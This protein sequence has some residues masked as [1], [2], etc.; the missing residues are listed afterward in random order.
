MT[1]K[2]TRKKRNEEEMVVV[3]SPIAKTRYNHLNTPDEYEG[4]KTFKCEQILTEEEL[5]HDGFRE[6]IEAVIEAAYQQALEETKSAKKRKEIE[7]VFPWTE[8]E[9]DEG[10]ETGDWLVRYK[11]NPHTQ[12][13]KKGKRRYPIVDAEGNPTDTLV[14]GG[15]VIRVKAYVK[16]YWMKSTNKVGATL[17]IQGIQI[18]EL[19]GGNDGDYGDAGFGKVEGGFTDSGG[20]SRDDGDDF[21]GDDDD[22][23]NDDF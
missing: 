6:K 1:Q 2:N 4:K 23:H 3:F 22:D 16:P 7:K 18:V 9:D 17:Y 13:K 19:A 11:S 5:D 12:G 8:E 15:S 21:D 10:E 20:S 14:F